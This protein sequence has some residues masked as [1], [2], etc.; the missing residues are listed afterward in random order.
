MKAKI[1]KLIRDNKFDSLKFAKNEKIN[2]TTVLTILIEL[3]KEG[4]IISKGDYYYI[5]ES[6]IENIKNNKLSLSKIK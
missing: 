5:V 4:K 1:L 6:N 2:D 3:K